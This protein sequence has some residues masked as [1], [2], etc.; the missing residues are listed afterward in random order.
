MQ[1]NPDENIFLARV[2]EQSEK[3]QDMIDFLLPNLQLKGLEITSD[4]R[5]LL[6][7]AFKNQ[8]AQ[9]K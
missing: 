4:E 9:I 1:T 5:N 8:V 2:A 6:S 3:Y 7:L